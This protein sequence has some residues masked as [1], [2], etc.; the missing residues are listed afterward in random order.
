MQ[1][2]EVTPSLTLH[3][4]SREGPTQPIQPASLQTDR[5]N[6][7]T[8]RQD[9]QS[10]SAHCCQYP[11]VGNH[12]ATS[13][14]SHTCRPQAHN[15][16]HTT[17]AHKSKA[18]NR[19]RAHSSLYGWR[20]NKKHTK[21]ATT[22][23]SQAHMTHGPNDCDWSHQPPSTP[24]V[25][26]LHNCCMTAAAAPH[27]HAPPP[28]CPTTATCWSKTHHTFLPAAETP[29]QQQQHHHHHCNSTSSD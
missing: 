5:Q 6:T 27:M 8:N 26:L 1:K 17:C 3:Q 14:G 22:G 15:A 18:T 25:T 20:G 11:P 9:T 23:F 19:R 24:C 4:N 2:S 29:N 28:S 13:T 16:A 10:V 21:Q 7:Q 12:T